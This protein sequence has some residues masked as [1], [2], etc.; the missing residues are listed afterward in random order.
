MAKSE[1]LARADFWKFINETFVRSVTDKGFNYSIFL[2]TDNNRAK[3]EMPK[4]F[5]SDKVVVFKDSS[6]H[7]S[8]D[9]N[10]F[11]RRFNKFE[12]CRKNRLT[13]F[14]FHML[15]ECDMAV[16]SHSGF[17]L[18]GVWRRPKPEKG[19]FIYSTEDYVKKGI[20]ANTNLKF[21]KLDDLD[22]FYFSF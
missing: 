20:F 3:S 11:L 7:F 21:I 13:I 4:L 18:L 22:E 2:T 15:Q 17:G 8:E 12:D 9:F 6:A 10:G 19:L 1:S 14:D 5:G 16:V